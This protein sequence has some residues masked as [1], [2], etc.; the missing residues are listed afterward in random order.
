VTDAGFTIDVGEVSDLEARVI[1]RFADE[2]VQLSGCLRG[3]FCETA[4]TL[5][6]EYPL[7]RLAG[8]NSAAEAIVTDPCAW[9]P[10]LPHLYR[11]EVEAIRGDA[12]VATYYGELG[13]RRTSEPKNWDH[14][15]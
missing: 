11:V 15:K 1:V 2:N 14:I 8:Q 7:V 6:A 5:P 3:P 4:H 12:V 13:L 9:S 10:E